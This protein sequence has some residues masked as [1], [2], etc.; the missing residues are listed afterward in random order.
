MNVKEDVTVLL[1]LE[2][3]AAVKAS[4]DNLERL[5]KSVLKA[6]KLKLAGFFNYNIT[7]SIGRLLLDD[8][9]VLVKVK[10]GEN[11][12]VMLDSCL[13]SARKLLHIKHILVNL[14]H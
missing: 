14:E 9:A 10:G 4:A 6:V 3:T 1:G 11:R 5:N 2:H 8:V 12:G 13:Q 7:Q